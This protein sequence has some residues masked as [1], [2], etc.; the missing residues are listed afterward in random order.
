MST[1][2]IAALLP[3]PFCGGEAGLVECNDVKERRLGPFTWTK[4]PKGGSVT[5]RLVRPM[6]RECHVT[7]SAKF[8]EDE[9]AAE[10]WNT[11]AAM[12]AA[13]EHPNDMHPE[14]WRG[15]AA[16]VKALHTEATPE[17]QAEPVTHREFLG[18]LVRAEWIKWARE[19]EDQK[20]TWLEP[21][22]ALT[23][24]M[25]E[26]DRRIGE[27]LWR[28]SALQHPDA[29][30]APAP[31]QVVDDPLPM[32]YAVGITGSTAYSTPAPIAQPT[33]I[34]SFIMSLAH[35]AAASPD[36][37]VHD[38]LGSMGYVRATAAPIMQPLTVPMLLGWAVSRWRHEVQH[39]PLLN[40]NRRALD[41][42]WRQVIRFADGDPDALIGPSHDALLAAAGIGAQEQDKPVAMTPEQREADVRVR[43]DLAHRCRRRDGGLPCCAGGDWRSCG[44]AAG[45]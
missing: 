32:S 15:Y 5:G 36:A 12:A 28:F 16:G 10:F 8:T 35:A 33:M 30:Q 41:D 18:K 39:R 29:P 6:C 26:V 34:E 3:C 27:A 37:S 7:C 44:A 45:H 23:E 2:L 4:Y 9:F 24:P 19:Q 40:K 25:R 42:T 43:R 11:R 21:W 17:Q 1:A 38:L 14:Y 20:P 13:P 22:E 31:V